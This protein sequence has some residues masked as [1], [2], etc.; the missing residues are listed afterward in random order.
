MNLNDWRFEDA[1]GQSW[2]EA[3]EELRKAYWRPLRR[4]LLELGTSP[5]A[6]SE[7]RESYLRILVRYNMRWAASRII[8][9]SEEARALAEGLL[10]KRG[11]KF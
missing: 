3:K 5:A 10:A 9:L 7:A 1:N 6:Y 4:L 8:P 2:E 11:R